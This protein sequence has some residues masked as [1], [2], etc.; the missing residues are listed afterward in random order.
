[1]TCTTVREMKSQV[2]EETGLGQDEQTVLYRGRP[3]QPADHLSEA[4]VSVGDTLNIIKKRNV[5]LT[6]KVDERGSSEQIMHCAVLAH[7]LG[8]IFE[9]AATG[10]HKHVER[11]S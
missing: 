3:L 9:R 6:G 11:I 10:I 5:E 8:S 2:E 7:L 4:G 1:M